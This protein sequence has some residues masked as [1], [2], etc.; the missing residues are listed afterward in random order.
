MS[1][2]LLR[3]LRELDWTYQSLGQVEGAVYRVI[4]VVSLYTQVEED[5]EDVYKHRNNLHKS[6]VG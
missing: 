4:K 5:P 1:L 6:H 2:E 3:H